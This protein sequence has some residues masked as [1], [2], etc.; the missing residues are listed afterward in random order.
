MCST[1]SGALKNALK[2][3][4][5]RQ[6]DKAVL[7]GCL[8]GICRHRRYFITFL[9]IAAFTSAAVGLNQIYGAAV[10]F[11]LALSFFAASLICLL[12][13]VRIAVAGLAQIL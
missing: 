5:R 6:V 3:G 10:L 2:V 8:L 12:L 4:H 7:A 1:L 11:V 9:V 13:E